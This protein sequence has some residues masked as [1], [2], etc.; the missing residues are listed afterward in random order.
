MHSCAEQ[1][2]EILYYVGIPSFFRLFFFEAL[3][4]VI[5]RLGSDLI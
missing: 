5:A 1:E 2:W 3:F 4:K